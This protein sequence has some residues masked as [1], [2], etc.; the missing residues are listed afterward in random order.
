MSMK[1]SLGPILYFWERERVIDFYRQVADWP[2]DIVYLGE[3]VCSKRRALRLEDWLGIAGTLA[4]AGKEVVLST[5]ALV[6]AESELGAMRRVVTNGVYPVEANDVAVLNMLDGAGV[7]FV[8]GPMLNVYNG[9]TLE[10]LQSLGARR[11]VLP[12]ELS[13]A[14]LAGLQARRPARL[15]TEVFGF[16]RL[17]LALSARCF[18]ARTHALPKD[19]CEFCC[20]DYPDGL[21][22]QTR[23]GGRF[24]TLNG[25][26]TQS[27]GVCNLVAELP[28][29]RAAGVD[30][31]RLS[32][33]SQHM[34]EIV[35]LFHAVANDE[36]DPAVAE[37]KLD[38]FLSGGVC[39]GYWHGAPGMAWQPAAAD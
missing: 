23:E 36:L 24:L 20:R 3:V 31:V 16:G 6:E 21:A 13:R 12:V 22:L 11:W 30:V 1:L 32:P 34:A 7:P 9:E 38:P 26:Q 15:E 19:A 10:L 28:E 18:T 37:R 33:Q 29:F 8:A 4:L 35:A 2:V 25:I 39:N 14:A 27:G 17:P 5:L